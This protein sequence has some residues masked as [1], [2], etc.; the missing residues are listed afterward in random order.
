[1]DGIPVSLMEAMAMEIPV[2][3]T[4]VSGIPELIEDGV[5]GLL[6]PANDAPALARALQRLVE[7]SQLRLT[8]GRNG[9][10]RIQA[11]F[12]IDKSVARL[13]VLFDG[14]AQRQPPGAST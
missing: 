4:R 14:P 1:M 3:S 10:R 7:D 2:I 6:V 5:S 13:A 8:L 11:E 9:R 12:D